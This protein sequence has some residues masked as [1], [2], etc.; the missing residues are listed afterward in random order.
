[1]ASNPS[2]TAPEYGIAFSR[3]AQAHRPMAALDPARARDNRR[4]LL[5]TS[6]CHACEATPACDNILP[7]P[8][9]AADGLPAVIDADGI[10]QLKGALP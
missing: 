5:R 2:V 8:Y 6:P 1:M 7:F 4:R 9:P 3:P 10:C